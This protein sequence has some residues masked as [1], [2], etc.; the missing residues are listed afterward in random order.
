MKKWTY[1]GLD[2]A[3]LNEIYFVGAERD[4]EYDAEGKL[5]SEAVIPQVKAFKADLIPGGTFDAP[6]DWQPTPYPHPTFT[7]AE[8][9]KRTARSTETT[10]DAAPGAPE[11]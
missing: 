8:A 6:D 3:E 1:N 5:V 11:V 4:A 10:G 7:E 2:P 9:K